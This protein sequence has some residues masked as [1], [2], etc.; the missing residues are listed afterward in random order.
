MRHPRP[1]LLDHYA[2]LMRDWAKL[3][4]VAGMALVFGVL[5]SASNQTETPITFSFRAMPILM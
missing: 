1:S 4:H 3:G 2:Q 5:S